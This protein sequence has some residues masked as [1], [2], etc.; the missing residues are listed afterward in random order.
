[1]QEDAANFDA[2]FKI[3]FFSA[4]V[5]DLYETVAYEVTRVSDLTTLLPRA[6]IVD[7]TPPT[8]GF[9]IEIDN[10]ECLVGQGCALDKVR[11]GFVTNVGTAN[12]VYDLDPRTLDG[13]ST[14]WVAEVRADTTGAFRP[15][16]DDYALVW[17]SP[18]D[19]VYRPPR[20]FGYLQ[21]DV[22]VFPVNLTRGTS[23]DLLIED[24]NNSGALDAGDE[25]VLADREGGRGP[26]RFRYR[27]GFAAADQ[28]NSV[29]PSA[30]NRLQVKRASAVCDR[31]LLSVYP[32]PVSD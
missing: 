11:T 12:E 20:L 30:G 26:W 17:A 19:S 8:D 24:L 3:A 28:G 18:S 2:V 7:T 22:P 1:M 15:S 31:G 4:P 10:V 23:Q 14:N 9:V 13:Y 27:I 5:D 29:E 6:P 25:V 21:A 16:A 32:A